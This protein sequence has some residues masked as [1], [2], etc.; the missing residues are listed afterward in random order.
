MLPRRVWF[1]VLTGWGWSL[2]VLNGGGV[3]TSGGVGTVVRTFRSVV[4]PLTG[5]CLI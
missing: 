4:L 1:L 2:I 3:R 5:V